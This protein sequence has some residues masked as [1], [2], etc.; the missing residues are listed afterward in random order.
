MKT[1]TIHNYLKAYLF[2]TM[3]LLHSQNGTG[4]KMLFLHLS[5]IW[6][7]WNNLYTFSLCIFI[8]CI[9]NVFNCL[10]IH[11]NSRKYK[12]HCH[13]FTTLYIITYLMNAGYKFPGRRVVD[14]NL[15]DNSIQISAF[16]LCACFFLYFLLWY[17]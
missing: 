7:N 9:F 17:Y 16:N 3:V 11:I 13:S 2:Q 14:L 1:V 12:H 6:H 8:L 4:Q 15:W 10:H 5:A